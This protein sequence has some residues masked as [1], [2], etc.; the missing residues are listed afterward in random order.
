MKRYLKL[1]SASVA[2]TICVTP[3]FG[4]DNPVSAQLDAFWS[5]ISRT[6][7]EGDFQAYRET[8][9][10]DAVLVSGISKTSQPIAGALSAWEAGFTETRTG[11]KKVTL[12]F[13]FTERINDATTAHETGI[14]CYTAIGDDGKPKT[15][16]IHFEALLI[17]QERWKTMMEYQ[18]AM[19]TE[20]E[21]AA[22]GQ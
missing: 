10:E 9:H 6:V 5:E 3:A 12:E 19:A 21:W 15:S 20:E 11:N 1:W 22:A 14:F 18:V 8:Y 16:Y 17:R 4:I 13:R 2:L 7:M